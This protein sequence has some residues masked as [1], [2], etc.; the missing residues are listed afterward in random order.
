MVSRRARPLA[1]PALWAVGRG[2]VALLLVCGSCHLAAGIE[3]AEQTDGVGGSCATDA[4]CADAN[5]CTIDQC[6]AG[7]CSRELL[8]GVDAPADAQTA[9]DCQRITCN[10]GA[11]ESSA[12]D[13]DLPVDEQQCTEDLC[14]GGVPSN[15]AQAAG[16][17][18]TQHGG[19]V[20]NG[21]GSCTECF[22]DDQC[23]APQTCGGG[24]T[25]WACGCTP[26]S[27]ES[28]GLTCGNGQN[29]GCGNPTFNC[30]NGIR[31][32]SETDI[33]CGGDATTCA[34]RCDAEKTCGKPSDCASGNC[35]SGSCLG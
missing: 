10:G 7:M 15:K 23:T 2:L 13:D 20:C 29:D 25:A 26:V 6:T 33:D 21:E 4:D 28:V 22:S 11:E 35:V 18:C 3:D 19:A 1:P 30:D 9:E 5:S 16:T 34:T 12:D 32:G 14:A 24:E 8:D 27:C 31:D 17:A